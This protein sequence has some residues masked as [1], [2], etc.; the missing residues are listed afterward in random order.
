MYE[1][2]WCAKEAGLW[3]RFGF[4]TYIEKIRI[5]VVGFIDRRIP[6]RIFLAHSARKKDQLD[7]NGIG[8][9]KLWSICNVRRWT[10]ETWKCQQL[11]PAWY[12]FRYP[13]TSILM[14]WHYRI[15]IR[16]NFSDRHIGIRIWVLDSRHQWWRIISFLVAQYTV[17]LV[18]TWVLC[19][20]LSKLNFFD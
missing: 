18:L 3:M 1:P 7:M 12:Y 9:T 14:S 10:S 4:C 20:R 8:R 11:D 16:A 13:V 6:S 19:P 5:L 15:G 2:Q 17:S